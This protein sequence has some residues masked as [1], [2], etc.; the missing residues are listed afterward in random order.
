[1][2]TDQNVLDDNRKFRALLYQLQVSPT[3]QTLMEPLVAR[4]D[5]RSLVIQESDAYSVGAI[6]SGSLSNSILRTHFHENAV[7]SGEFN[8]DHLLC[9][10]NVV[11]CLSSKVERIPPTTSI[12]RHITSTNHRNET[13]LPDDSTVLSL[14][15]RMQ[16]IF[17]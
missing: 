11:C 3:D 12:P 5:S 1:M 8:L 13:S 15:N 2:R 10:W 4:I 14:G 16:R 9:Q 6:L 7:I 17:S